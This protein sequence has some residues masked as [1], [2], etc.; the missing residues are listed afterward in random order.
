VVRVHPR[1]LGLGR[2]RVVARVRFESASG[3][4]PQPFGRCAQQQVAPRF[5]G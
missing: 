2:H 4:A 5:T 3:T 1:S